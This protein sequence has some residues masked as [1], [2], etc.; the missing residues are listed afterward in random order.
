MNRRD[1]F[2]GILGGAGALLVG[3]RKKAVPVEDVQITT[4]GLCREYQKRMDDILR[5][6]YLPGVKDILNAKRVHFRI[7]DHGREVRSPVFHARA[8]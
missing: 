3:L 2:R 5:E 6:H 8:D 1:L 4:Y 7:Y